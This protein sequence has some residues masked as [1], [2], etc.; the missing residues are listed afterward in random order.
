MAT[1]TGPVINAGEAISLD[2][3]KASAFA[4]NKLFGYAAAIAV[5]GLIVLSQFRAPVEFNLKKGPAKTISIDTDKVDREVFAKNAGDR[6]QALEVERDQLQRMIEQDHRDKD[7]IKAQRAEVKTQISLRKSK[8][9]MVQGGPGGAPLKP[10]APGT[11]PPLPPPLSP[12][13]GSQAPVG[14]SVV[15]ASLPVAKGPIPIAGPQG[16]VL[17]NNPASNGLQELQGQ[18]IRTLFKVDPAVA[19]KEPKKTFWLPMGSIIPVR[20]LSGMDAPARAGQG[21]GSGS[22]P[23]G[24]PYPVLMVV[25]DLAKLPNAKELDARECF[26]LGEGVGELS[27]ER[28]QIRSTGISCVKESG[29]AVELE[30]KG[31]INGEDGKLGM[32][33]RVVFKEGGLRGRALFAGLVSGISQA[34]MPYQQGIVVANSPSQAFNMPPAGPVAMAGAA[35][36]MG[37]AARLLA[38]HY[39]KM[40]ASIFPII[41][42]DAQRDVDFVVGTG[43]E[44]VDYFL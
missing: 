39:S 20:L 7:L 13:A 15:Q 44:L 6:I 43:R 3:E 5:V 12:V 29:E 23:S 19:K 36:G 22:G 42:I 18:G 17:S 4:K 34:F 41:E 33:G 27:S 37:N 40:A 38:Q 31:F 16:Q 32:R 24:S 10:G 26:L 9:V 2:R 11:F 21:T 28:V 14:G 35:G 1:Q 30:V 8:G 25:R